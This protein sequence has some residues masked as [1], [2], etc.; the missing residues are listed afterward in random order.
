VVTSWI[1][2]ELTDEESGL[3]FW[4][5]IMELVKHVSRAATLAI[6]LMGIDNIHLCP[7]IHEVHAWVSH[8]RHYHKQ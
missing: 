3:G 4:V 5:H 2:D 7:V 8:L 6:E 1:A